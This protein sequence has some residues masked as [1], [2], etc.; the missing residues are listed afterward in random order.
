MNKHLGVIGL[1]FVTMV[2]GAGFV[3]SDIA[4]ESLSPWWIMS[5]R[6]LI[7][8]IVMGVLSFKK[9]KTITITELK[10]G[11]MLGTSLFGAFALQTIGL[12]FTTP[13]KNAFLTATNVVMVPFIAFIVLKKKTSR[14][15][16]LGAMLAIIGAGVLS[17]QSD[18][19]L[20]LGDT[21]T[22]LGAVCFAFQ[23]FLTGEFVAKIRPFAL[24]FMQMA[25]ACVLSFLGLMVSGEYMTFAPASNGITAVLYLGLIS[26]TLSYFIQTHSQKYVDETKAA[27]IL[28]TESIFGTFFSVII[29]H[30]IITGRMIIGSV[31][32]LSAVILSELKIKKHK[33]VTS[34]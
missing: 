23:I 29:L 21:L 18:F 22:L 19:S 24:M 11:I 17:L 15:N 14:Q 20:G 8:T 16:I 13:S 27:I 6:F 2:W 7:A 1:L 28:S 12:Q 5:F 32:I 25:T 9:I 3:A 33:E 4:L 31:L 26:T 34:K 10:C 30:E